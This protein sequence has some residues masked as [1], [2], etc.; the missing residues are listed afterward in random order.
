MDLKNKL[1]LAYFKS[2]TNPKSFLLLNDCID[3]F[4]NSVDMLDVKSSNIL[5]I[6][7]NFSL[8][9]LKVK[10]K[11]GSIYL[12]SNVPVNVFLNFTKA[13][14]IG[15]YFHANIKMVDYKYKKLN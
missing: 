8:S 5:Q 10:F 4:L 9:E 3:K 1:K 12:Y 11:G 15:K 7:Y 14:S 6:G 13:D 2:E